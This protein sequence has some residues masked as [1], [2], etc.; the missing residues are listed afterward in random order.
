[1][2]LLCGSFEAF[3]EEL[4]MTVQELKVAVEAMRESLKQKNGSIVK[5]SESG[6]VGIS[7]IESIVRALEAQEER[8]NRLEQ[9][10]TKPVRHEISSDTIEPKNWPS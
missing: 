1:L 9:A 2:I 10:P 4:P 8:I 5:A 7:I 3:R 6:P